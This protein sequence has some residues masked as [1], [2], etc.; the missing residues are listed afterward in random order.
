MA[1]GYTEPVIAAAGLWIV[2]GLGCLPLLGSSRIRTTFEPWP[3]DRVGVNYL[4][5][6]GLLVLG[7]ALVF[8]GG[9]IVTGG[10]SGMA[11]IR[12][13]VLVASGYAPAVWLLLGLVTRATGVGPSRDED[14]YQ[15]V[16]LGLGAL[17]YGVVTVVATAVVFL[18]LFAL[19]FPG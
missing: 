11:L 3:T 4:V 19:F 8:L 5:I 14:G 10:F 13:A 16:A 12:W 18:I 9:V 7:Q 15:W 1:A 6:T 2:V 17:W